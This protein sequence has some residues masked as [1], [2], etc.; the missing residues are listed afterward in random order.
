MAHCIEQDDKMVYRLSGGAP[1]HDLGEG[2][3]DEMSDQRFF[4]L[5]LDW[6]VLEYPLMIQG[7]VEQRP[8]KFKSLIRSSDGKE[9]AVASKSYHP[10]QN[11]QIFE[12]FQKFCEAGKMKLETV[13][14]LCG[15]TKVWA[16]GKLGQ[17]GFDVRPGD[18]TE[19]Y[20]LMSTGHE[21]GFATQANLTTMRVVCKNTLDV[22]RMCDGAKVKVS[23][24]AVWDDRYQDKAVAL[25]EASIA[26]MEGHRKQAV[27]LFNTKVEDNVNR[28]YLVE[29]FQPEL[30]KAV[31]SG[32]HGWMIDGI[33]TES[34]Q[35][36]GARLL[37]QLIL[38][39]EKTQREAGKRVMDALL[40]S[41]DVASVKDEMSPSVR[42]VESLIGS[43]PGSKMVYGTL[44]NTYNAVSYYVDHVRGRSASSAIDSALFG[45][46]RVLKQTALDLAVEYSQRLGVAGT[47][48]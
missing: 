48:Q 15:G 20:A 40:R 29:L 13:G 4:D 47:I 30:V 9:L 1:W 28:A 44:W 33:I 18:R 21:P 7:R 14:S 12:F 5:A 24:R 38:H 19:M 8:S 11:T 32:D 26:A 16:L 46:G 2:I 34:H 31:M 36:A 3:G 23:H 17:Q 39:D 42:R 27:D 35:E 22:G 45:E 6:K 41:M 10:V 25:V 43:Q 37:A